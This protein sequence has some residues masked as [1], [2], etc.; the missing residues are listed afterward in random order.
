M[1][2]MIVQGQREL[3]C[4]ESSQISLES[5]FRFWELV[6]RSV[7]SFAEVKISSLILFFYCKITI[8]LYVWTNNKII[9]ILYVCMHIYV[10]HTCLVLTEARRHCWE[11]WD[12]SQM[13]VWYYVGFGNW[14]APNHWT[15]FPIYFFI[16]PHQPHLLYQGLRC[17][18]ICSAYWDIFL[19]SGWLGS[20]GEYITSSMAW[21]NGATIH[22]ADK[23][24][25]GRWHP[26]AIHPSICPPL[27]LT[28]L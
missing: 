18:C 6:K 19:F 22:D 21:E 15:I 5:V 12:W 17:S 4:T 20:T 3:T 2:A 8:M 16:F 26:S 25:L 10:L 13:I 23:G 24:L 28:T 7:P 9:N 11:P 1:K 27:R 14:S